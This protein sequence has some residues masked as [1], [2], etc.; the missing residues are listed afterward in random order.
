MCLRISKEMR[1]SHQFHEITMAYPCR[2][3]CTERYKLILNLTPDLEFPLASDI[4][5]SESWQGI[6]KR[7]DKMMGRRPV[8]SFLRRPREELYDL[9][10]DP[11]ELTNVAGDPAYAEIL[12]DLRR[13]L[14]AW[15]QETNDPWLI[16]DRRPR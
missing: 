14:R 5:G 4:W 2:A 7:G 8:S 9:G 6:L 13:R 3:V 12:A 16:L 1:Q 15:R 11:N 10:K